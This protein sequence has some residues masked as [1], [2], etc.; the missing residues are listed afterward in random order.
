MRETYNS[1]TYKRNDTS[2]IEVDSY[3][4]K[5]LI[6]LGEN[7]SFDSL[8]SSGKNLKFGYLENKFKEIVGIDGIDKDVVFVN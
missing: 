2:T 3:E 6:L 1:K 7:Q 4:L 8:P 5:R